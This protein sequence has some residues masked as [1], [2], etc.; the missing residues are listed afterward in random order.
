VDKVGDRLKR[1]HLIQ[2]RKIELLLAV[3]LFVCGSLLLYD[4]FDARGKDVPW[5]LNK[6]T[7]W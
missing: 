6:L 5:P 4:A 7:P 2:D 3:I 1:K